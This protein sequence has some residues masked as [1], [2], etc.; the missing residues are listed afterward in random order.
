MLSNN[1]TTYAMGETRDNYSP[2][3][4]V[5]EQIAI[6]GR[7]DVSCPWSEETEIVDKIVLFDLQH[8]PNGYVFKLETDDVESGFIQV[9]DISGI[10]KEN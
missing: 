9:H 8:I 1:L 10:F 6:I 4:F 3:E 7:N 5:L 2:E